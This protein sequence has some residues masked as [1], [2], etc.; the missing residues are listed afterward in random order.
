MW[1]IVFQKMD[2]ILIK[3]LIMCLNLRE[4]AFKVKLKNSFHG[5]FAA[6]RA[7]VPTQEKK[8]KIKK[9]LTFRKV[10][11]FKDCFLWHSIFTMF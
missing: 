5:I 8:K 9:Q 6:R 1:L 11:W 10:N 7:Y 4:L 2:Y 3:T